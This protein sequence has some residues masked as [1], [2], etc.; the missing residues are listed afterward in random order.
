MI[1]LG[2]KIGD[3]ARVYTIDSFKWAWNNFWTKRVFSGFYL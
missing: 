1:I 3:F 2:E